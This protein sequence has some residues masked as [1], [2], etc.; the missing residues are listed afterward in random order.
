VELHASEVVSGLE[1]I[2]AGVVLAILELQLGLDDLAGAERSDDESSEDVQS[3]VQ[4]KAV[5]YLS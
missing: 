5:S 3:R 1:E 2:V 4:H